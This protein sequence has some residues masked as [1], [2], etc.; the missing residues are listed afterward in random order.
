L[1]YLEENEIE[2]GKVVQVSDILVFNQTVTL[3][4]KGKPVTLGFS[5]ARQIFVEI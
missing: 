5:I 3:D 4:V 2:P 1:S